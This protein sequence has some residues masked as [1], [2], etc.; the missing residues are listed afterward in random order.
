METAGALPRGV[1]EDF[2]SSK[3]DPGVRSEAPAWTAETFGEL[4]REVHN[5]SLQKVPVNH[6]GL[7]KGFLLACGDL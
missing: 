2:V 3:D 5:Y 4:G 6:P 1:G 7:R